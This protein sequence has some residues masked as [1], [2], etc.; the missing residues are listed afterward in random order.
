MTTVKR[1]DTHTITFT[2]TDA[3][4]APVDITDSTVRLLARR[5][6]VGASLIVLPA[7]VTDA[8]NGVVSH[9]LTGTLEASTY[10]VELE[11][12]AD[13][14]MTTAPSDGYLQLIVI[15]DLRD[16]V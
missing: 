15:Q 8:T 12:T 10:D 2:V 5:R 7:T 3:A 4:G 11:V 6:S 16:P 14:E 9:T 1:G 13:G